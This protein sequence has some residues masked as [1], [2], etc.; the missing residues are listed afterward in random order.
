MN[1]VPAAPTGVNKNLITAATVL[2]ALALIV[3]GVYFF[4]SGS[5]RGP[6]KTDFGTSMPTDFPA[7]VPLESGAQV[8]QSY[9]LDYSG[10]KQLTYVFMSRK[11][12][13]ENYT[14]YTDFLNE[15]SWDLVNSYESPAL[16]SLY[17]RKEGSDINVTISEI[18]SSPG[19]RSQ[20]SISILKK[21]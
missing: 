2:G 4:S 7:D 20:V 6:E 13:E 10:Q 11:T 19:L 3:V 9:S 18:A 12:V 1:P 16:S 14:L 15:Q 5:V 8:E 17:G 21:L